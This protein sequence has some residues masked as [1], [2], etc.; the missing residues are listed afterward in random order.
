MIL[1]I[2]L[3][4]LLVLALILDVAALAS[5]PNFSLSVSPSSVDTGAAAIATTTITVTPSGG[6]SGGV[7]LSFDG[8]PPGVS[9]VLVPGTEAGTTVLWFTVS[10][11]T[12]QPSTT[13]LT[14]TGTGGGVT[15]TV[16]IDLTVAG[17]LSDFWIFANPAS[18]T[19]ARGSSAT[20]TIFTTALTRFTDLPTFSTGP[21]PAGVTASFGPTTAIGH[22]GRVTLTLTAASTALT[23]SADVSV[24]GRSGIVAVTTRIPLTVS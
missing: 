1:R 3:V 10:N 14:V 20:V 16:E 15:H 5:G 6:F 22:A 7:R 8:V 9:A 2:R 18:L 24:K 17:R 13:T 4:P 21:L 23:G 12:R 19:V 11:A